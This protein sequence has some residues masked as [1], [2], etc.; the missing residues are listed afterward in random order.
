MMLKLIRVGPPA[1]GKEI[2]NP[3]DVYDLMK[4]LTK[5]DR[6]EMYVIH[7]DTRNVTIATE[8]IGVG[9]LN[10][11]LVHPREVFKAAI[12]NN[13]SAIILVHNHP[14]GNPKASPEDVRIT[15]RIKAAGEICGIE[16]L[17]HVIIGHKNYWTWAT[18]FKYPPPPEPAMEAK[19]A[20]KGRKKPKL[21]IIK[22]GKH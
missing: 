5:A 19:A 16:M 22:G 20:E 17:D 1:R 10:S 12:L 9:C 8:R 13:S 3:S 14:S 4:R 21:K 6:E 7:L 11:C 2:N 18:N 15:Q